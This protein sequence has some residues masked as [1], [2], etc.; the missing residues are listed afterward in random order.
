MM[1][2]PW[3]TLTT[4]ATPQMMFNPCAMTARTQPSKRPS[5]RSVRKSATKS[6]MGSPAP[7]LRAAVGVLA[8]PVGDVCGQDDFLRSRLPL[9]KDHRVRDLEAARVDLEFPEEVHDVHAA[10]L[11]PDGRR[12]EVVRPLDRVRQD[13][14]VGALQVV[15]SWFMVNSPSV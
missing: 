14:Q 1:N 13:Q 9:H 2:S 7:D 12:V 11:R 10:E 4:F 15:L 6:A 3:A 8:R 5:T